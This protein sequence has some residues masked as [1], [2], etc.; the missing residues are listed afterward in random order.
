[1]HT[2][3]G[4]SVFNCKS[5]LSNQVMDWLHE[6]TKLDKMTSIYAHFL[7]IKGLF[8]EIIIIKKSLSE[9]IMCP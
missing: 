2:F 6:K 7:K 3:T 4:K 1:M 5:Y 8:F 9:N